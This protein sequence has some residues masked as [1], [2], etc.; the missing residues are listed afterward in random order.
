MT[1][2]TGIDDSGPVEYYF[3]ETSGHSG[4]TDSGWQTSTSYIDSGLS[5]S[6]EYTYTVTLRDRLG[7]TGSA[8]SAA[9]ATTQNHVAPESGIETDGTEVVLSWMTVSGTSY[10]VMWTTNLTTGSWIDITNGISGNDARMS[11]TNAITE[12]QQFF[13][14]YREE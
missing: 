7:N 2:T 14:V 9:S 11:V 6:T 12:K 3:A 8:S 4:G 5:T 1:A 13:Q 10:G